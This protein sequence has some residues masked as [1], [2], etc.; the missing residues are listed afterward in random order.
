MV[1]GV[2][3]SGNTAIAVEHKNVVLDTHAEN[4]V[5]IQ[6]V[7]GDDIVNAN[8][9]RMPTM[10]SGVVS[11][12]AHAGDHVV[13]SVNG[14]EFRGDVVTD[15]NGQL[16]YNIP[17][18]TQALNEGSNDVQVMVTG[19]DASG[20]T[21]IAVEHKNVVLDTHAENHVIIQPVAG[22]D[23]VNAAESRMPTMISGVV[24]GDAQAGD[25]VVVSV[26]GHEYRGDVVADANG[27]L[28]YE[29]PVPTHALNEGSNDVQVM[30][31]GVDASGNTAIAVE[32][33]NVVLDTHAENHVIIQTVAGDNV[34]NAAESRMPT[35]ISGVVSGDAHAGDHVVVSVN[36]HEY[37]G[38]VVADANGQLRYEVPVP[39]HA[40]NEGNNDVQVMVTGVDASG[41]T[42]IVVEHQNVVLD[43]HAENHVIIQPV[44]GDDTVNANESRM[45]TMISGVVSGDAHA[46]DHVVVSVNGHEY[47]GDVVADENGQLRYEVPV[48]T[49][50]LNEGS[51]DVQVMVTGVDASGNTA[52]AVEH[53]NVVLDTHAENH[54]IIQTVAGDNVVNAA[55]SRMPTM[56]SGV[57]S[58]DAHA[59]DHVVVS[60]NGHEYRGDVVADANGQLRYEVPVPTH[61]LNEGN[62]DVQVM[63]TGVDASGNTAIAVEHKNVVLDTHAENHVII[64]TVAG[65]NVVNGAE[66]RMPTMISGVVSGDAQV[67]DRVVVSVNGHEYRGDVVA[68]ENGQLRYEVPVPTHALNE[69]SN[70]VQVMVTGTDSAGNTAI[71]VEHKTVVLD[72]QAHNAL[73]IE[74]VAGDDTVNA[75]E[76]RMPTLISGE[77]SGDAQAG[78]HVVV[79][80]NGHEFRGDVVTDENGQLRY[81]IPVPTNALT[82]GSNDVQVMVTGTDSAGNT[83]IAVEHKTVVVDTQA[84]NALTIETV[85][86]DD[87]V[88]ATE[89]RM[90]TMISGVVSGD[91]QAGDHVV[92]SVNGHEFRGDVVTDE[93]GQLRYEIPVPTN[94]LTEGSNDVQVMVTGTDSAGNTAIAVEH[95]T[96]VLDTQAH[97][98][99]T[100]ET[101]A[102]DDTVNATE[103]RMPTLISGEVSGDAHAGDHVVVSVNGHE[104]RGNVV[105]DENGQLRYEIPVPTN[106]LTEGSNDVQVMVTGTDSAGNTAI[107]VEHKTVVLDTQAH[108][109]LTIETV[110]GDDTVNATESR[111]PTLISGE[112]S[113]DAQEGDHVV[114]SVNG[115]EFRGDVVTDENGQ[116]RYEIP[117]P[118]NA[119]TEGSNDVQVMVTGTDSAGNATTAV[120]HKTVVLDTQAHNALTIETVAGDDTVN[121]TESRMPTMISGVVSGDAQA[122]DHVVVSVNGQN[123]YG[124]VTDENGQLRY[125]VPVATAALSEGS[126]DVQVM[127]TGTDSA[128]NA[129]TAIEHKTVV[130]D[131]HAHNDLTID[132]VARDDIVNHAESER[133]VHIT[134]QV[135][136]KDAQSG[137]LVDVMV[138]GHHFSGTVYADSQGHLY[139]DVAIP[140]DTLV[141]GDTH[142]Q[143]T[144]TSQDNAGNTAI[145]TH[146]HDFSVDLHAEATITVNGVTEDNKLSHAELETPKQLITGEV[147]GD[148]RVGDKVSIEIN[149]NHFGGKVID[150]GGGKL[151]YQI[152][153][154]SS[155]FGDNNAHIN[156]DV[157]FTASVT[158]HD[159]VNNEVTQT[160]THTV[161]VDN[162]ATNGFTIGAVADDNVI[163]MTE[164]R[165]PTFISGT[166]S[167]DAKAGDPVEVSVNG[168]TYTGKV[169]GNPGH[170]YYN[171]AVPSSQLH[172][173]TNDVH[174]K[175]TSHD[176]LGNEAVTEHQKT[177]TVDT[178]AE[179]TVSIDGV[180]QDNVLTHS[181]LGHVHK[182]HQTITGLVGG[183][184]KAGDEVTIEINH[185]Y[186]VGHVEV[187][188]GHLGYQIPVPSVEFSDNKGQVEKDVTFT[189]KVISHDA[190]GNEAINVVE[191]TVHVDNFAVNDLTID[192]VAGEDW[193]SKAESDKNVIIRGAVTGDDAKAGDAVSVRVS[194]VDASGKEVHHDYSGNVQ[195]DSNGHLFYSVPVPPG[196]LYEGLDTVKVS[197]TSHDLVGNVVTT[198]HTHDIAVDTHADAS[199]SID[200]V[201]EDN[202]LNHDELDTHSQLI[203]GVVGGDARVGD[204]VNI[205]I[206]N[207]HFSGNVIDLGGKLGYQIPVDSTAFSDN[208]GKVD[209]KVNF[210]VS[211]TSHDELHNVVTVSTDHT[212]ILDNHAEAHITMDTVSGD[213][214]INQQESKQQHTTKVSGTV[215]GE[216]VHEGDKVLITVNNNTYETTVEHQPHLH[217][218]L[219]YS[220]DVSTRDIMADPKVTA[221]IVGHDG[222]LNYQPAEV[223]TDLKVDLQAEASI[224]INKVTGDNM[225]NGEESQHDFTTVSGTVGGDAKEGDLVTLHINN[226]DLTAKVTRD[227]SGHLVWTK[228]VSTHDLMADP[229]FTATVTVTDEAN[230]RASAEAKQDI[231]V[232]TKVEATISVDNVTADNTLNGDE[233]KHGYTLVSGKVTGEMQPG[234]PLTLKVNNH[235]YNGVVE[236]L[237]VDDQGKVIMGYHIPVV[238]TDIQANPNIHA[239]IDVTDT[240]KNH[241]VAT[242][243][244]NVGI[245][246]HAEASVTINIVSGDDVLNGLDQQSPNTIINGRVGG[247]V[248]DGDIV[249][250]TVDGV[251]YH[252]TVGPQTFLGGG[253]GYTLEVPTQGLV[254]NPHITAT[255]SMDDAAGNTATVG[256]T[257]DVSSDDHASATVTIDRVTDD[258]TINNAEAHLPHTTITGHVTGDVHLGDVVDLTVNGQHYYGAVSNQSNGLGY[259][260]DVSTD[261]LI[262]GGSKP[263]IHAEVTGSDAAG[264]TIRAD[265]DR[266]VNI[267]TRADA[268]IHITPG[269]LELNSSHDFWIMEGTVGGDAKEGDLI[270]ITAGGKTYNTHVIKDNLGH[271]VFNGDHL[272]D[273]TTGGKAYINPHDLDANAD[274]T[275][276][277]T[278]TDRYGNTETASDHMHANLP[279]PPTVVTDPNHGNTTTPPHDGNNG[280]TTT[281]TVPHVNITVSPVAGDN[282]I[283]N[284]ESKSDNGQTVIRGTVSGDVHVGDQVIIYLGTRPYHGEVFERPNLPGEYGYAIKVDT[285]ELQNHPGFSVTMF[286]GTSHAEGMVIF[287]TDVSAQIHLNDIAGDNTI[288]IVESQGGTTTISGTVSGDNIHAGS[289][290]T[291]M[292]NNHQITTQVSED[293]TTHKL[294][295][296]QEV[297]IDDLRQDPNVSVSVT[298]RDEH[299]NAITVTDGKTVAVDTE[300]SAHITVDNIT[301]DN[302]I[303]LNESKNATTAVTGKVSGDVNPGDHVTLTVN[304]HQ[305]TNIEVD[306]NLNYKVDVLTSDL[307]QG[308]SVTAEVTGHD[309]AGNVITTQETHGVS[310]DTSAGA[311]VT[312]NTV[313]GDNILSA[314]DLQSGKTE[315][316][317]VVGGDA[318]KGDV[319]TITVNHVPTQVTVIE[320]PNMNGQLGYVAQ[321]NTSDLQANPNIH[322]SVSG[323]DGAHNSFEAH[324]DKL[325]TI[326]DHANVSLN[327]NNVSGDNVLNAVESNQ[328]KT[329]ITGT[330]RGD[331]HAGDNVM[332]TVNGNTIPATLHETGGGSLAFTIQVD[333]VDLLQDQKITYSVTGVDEVGNTVTI[334]GENTVTIDQVASNKINIGTISGDDKVN[335]VE[336]DAGTTLVTGVV[337]G[338]AHAGD[339]VTLTVNGVSVPGGVVAEVNGKLTYEI[340]VSTS[341]LHE[342]DN[343]VV[344]TV[345]GHDAPGNI[346]TSTDTHT[347]TLDTQIH[348]SITLD[349]VAGNDVINAAESDSV[350]VKGVVSTDSDAKLGDEVTVTVN[351]KSFTGVVQDINGHPGYDIHVDKGYLHEG[352][353]TFDVSIKATDGA[354]NEITVHAGH[355]VLMDTQLNASITLDT[356]AGNN[357]INAAESDHVSVTGT[358]GR[359]VDAQL[360]ND[361]T[362]T[363]NGKSFTGEIK[364]INGHLGYDIPVDKGYL[365][366]GTNT[367]DV[368]VSATDAAGNA[369]T[370]HD[371]H[372]VHVDT[373][374]GAT[375]TLEPV[376][377]NDVINAA[378]ADHVSVKGVVSTD[379][380]AK[381]GDEVTVTVNGKSFTGVVQDINGHLGYDIP[382]D[383]GYL[384]E[385]TN[386]FD[387]S[388][389]ATDAAGNAITVHDSHDV[390]VDTQI[391][392][393]ITLEP[394]AA[395]DVI[396]AA[397]A[398]H[399]SVKGVVSTD[400]DAKLG[401]EVTVTVNG[402]SFTGVVQDINGHPG[403]DIHVDKGYLHEGTNTF[404][405]S[406]SATD[407]AGNAI[408]VHDSHDVHVDTQLG[409]T[410]TLE[411][412]AAN[413]V[414][415]AAAADHVSVTGTV[416][417]DSDAKLGDEVTVTVNG[418]SFTGVVQ[419]INGHPG[420]DIHV[421]KGYLHEGTNTFDV[422]IKATDGTGNEI[423]VHAGHD[424]H[425]D[426]QLGATITLEPV[427]GNDV[428]NAAESDHVSVKGVVST[429]SDAKLGDEVTV[430]VNGKSFTGVVQDINGHPGYDIHVDKGYLHE[431][432]N[433]FDVSIKSTDGAGNDITVHAGHEVLM[434]THLNATITLDTVS[435]NNVINAAESDH[436]SVTGT[437]GR[438]VD[439]QLGNEVTVTVNGKSFTGEI[440]V[441]NGH[442]GYDIHVDKG[443]LHEG[444][445]TFD[446]S[447]SA[448]D[449]AGNAITV[450]DS[451]DVLV[452]THADAKI[453]IDKVTG[454]NHIDSHE[455]HHHVTHITGQ[456]DSSDVNAND[457]MNATINGKHYD[458]TLHEDNGHL[459]YDIPVNTAE[460]HAGKNNVDVSVAAHDEH[461]NTNVFHQKA[462]ITMDDPSHRG[463]HDVDGSD[464]SLHAANAPSHDHGL[465]NLF[466]DDNDSFSF[467]LAHDSKGHH[468]DEGLKVF[469]GK[470]SAHFDKVDLSDLAH[471]LH[472]V[473]DIAQMIKVVEAPQHG[474]GGATDAVSPAPAVPGHAGDAHHA[475]YDSAGSATHSLDHLIPKPEQFH[476]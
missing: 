315:V 261:D 188:N 407:A 185:H 398:D 234:D 58:G 326:D 320:L 166:A 461:G 3:A 16:R 118:T 397:A 287:D 399:V 144:I 153:V 423:T 253:L 378:A 112:V 63:V 28:R 432:S 217:G 45:P 410:I 272:I 422:S 199:I 204:V 273:P 471:E 237:G 316:S 453:T 368:S 451:H 427:A 304:G 19:V 276:K 86:G 235:T 195:V 355:E 203:T 42:A 119:L 5:I 475:S 298:G 60:V 442:L 27:Q 362:V 467:N 44:A 8:E 284:T 347:I 1:T 337:T 457:H 290:V 254:H 18:P 352:S 425:V 12:D 30:V 459:T 415:N 113:G 239:S 357:V 309:A 154:D 322:V 324:S 151:G 82:E 465:S 327:I 141:E 54:V 182:T 155:A 142:A 388:V 343:T 20:N 375:I 405:V 66:S 332:V 168:Q 374:L 281:P 428:I 160:T 110:A 372:D 445:N 156:K 435:G 226:M 122:G 246:D 377:A 301:D 186:Y 55:E 294:V 227:S 213:N 61:A 447:V 32:H 417:T 323:E 94:A 275:V 380:D 396:N 14:H 291:L 299:G 222:A 424:V 212:V 183:D 125:T 206:N 449:K 325:L 289:N 473:T 264:N 202:V 236:N 48:P 211:V 132:T 172:E 302:I 426:T 259:S 90:P 146:T 123:F 228:E 176:K 370:V 384:Q 121:A 416:G 419:D 191:H 394:V 474:K 34:V 351:G 163:N 260:I 104:F 147:G 469:T 440:K 157:T 105:T 464:K 209:G 389:S 256:A 373:Q 50:A 369:I 243:D 436:V 9:S 35:M 36:G 288:N 134:G 196:G 24:S 92:V 382:V 437:V 91:A 458:V 81:E 67:G 149:G 208:Q 95:K 85:A 331:V 22:D 106:A 178:H 296:S 255:I 107:A 252:A 97:N 181:E 11:G 385:G 89:S 358:V 189:A 270:E 244:H 197:I 158:S 318:A 47:R 7:A 418:K 143:V 450:H 29:V 75:T 62:N 438:D 53:K 319:V 360:G 175:L 43:T 248:T 395:N 4:H 162:F 391:G 93:N 330:V 271:L 232:D 346:A 263:V 80:V 76:S 354:G 128:G 472:E 57:V 26:N 51:N 265:F 402:K 83:A 49:H 305:Y 39:T 242:A 342:G 193:V 413:D 148:A 361:V 308:K 201:T 41:N 317:G 164:S 295:F 421:D 444:K 225:I 329:E 311:T 336:H 381:L 216:D 282:W 285:D 218:A 344:V 274:I 339:P 40:L 23:V 433:T 150:L 31:T 207:H 108:N 267:D 251:V 266:V 439:A 215:S 353:N 72:T 96:V 341:V 99:L 277:I 46:G 400:S 452:D 100:I 198:S 349:P 231:V 431:G 348:A 171:V 376:A 366:E 356:V 238:T 200:K 268:E 364:V 390:H 292:V 476:S 404:D 98:A 365:H 420:Y 56:I 70:D 247:E 221:H 126:N 152:P 297:S 434:D 131:T 17:V 262:S 120:E 73:T 313:S 229:S 59:G 306:Q 456:V 10:I 460:L 406:V 463:K 230:N 130:L 129:T 249:D 180:T 116:L 414:I 401:D 77:V 194:S 135:S 279:W 371:S 167:G 468:G 466:G 443:Y 470:D 136:G 133:N 387:V 240:A 241:T 386:T 338:D 359:D 159:A 214:I 88:N 161:H 257:R 102:G 210:T 219:G 334:T 84:H 328:P 6:P 446:V 170:L 74:T 13:V 64:Q 412:V 68:D 65:D 269:S 340:P 173:G 79:S 430:T 392:A 38:D 363:V 303:N 184:A 15:E 145:A 345:T 114:V 314:K 101:V 124:T 250:V 2:D 454:D 140:R 409:A 350:S 192:T 87:T 293:L 33:Q 283:N 448:T 190:A 177:V 137:D 117:V 220:V 224:T 111:M 462:D 25:K 411:P 37:R 187:I 52:I 312:I 205:D 165:M 278:T 223:T 333:T 174:V 233:L 258:N 280:H 286:G 115:H 383:K 455:A 139:Y 69:G 127:V 300:V 109:A 103:S 307:M 245:D 379:S 403:Y 429:D 393:T 169:V 21:A 321:V 78:D 408:T 310:V 367:F 335:I 71:A 138:Q 441:I 179:N